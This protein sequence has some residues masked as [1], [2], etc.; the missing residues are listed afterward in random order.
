MS[1]ATDLAQRLLKWRFLRFLLVGVLNTLFGYAVYLSVLMLGVA[2]E[3]ALAVA[4]LVGAVFNYFSTGRLVFQ[5]SGMG[6]LPLFLLAY[7]VIYAANAAALRALLNAGM[8]A[9]WAQAFL[10]PTVAIAS[11]IIFKFFVFRTGSK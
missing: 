8:A 7:L 11:F 10:L 1:A 9:G 5:S 6:R 3:V 2:P 4:T